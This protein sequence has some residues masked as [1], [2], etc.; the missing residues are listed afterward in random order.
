MSSAN[1]VLPPDA[2]REQ[3]VAVMNNAHPAIQYYSKYKIQL[4]C[5]KRKL[6]EKVKQAIAAAG[7]NDSWANIVNIA[8]NN[9]ELQAALP[10]IR[11]TFGS[12]LV[13]EVLSE[14]IAE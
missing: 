12:A 5:Q 9:P 2:V 4:A 14:S 10:A 6:W 1:S 8:S 13:D 3:R 7:M 11:Q